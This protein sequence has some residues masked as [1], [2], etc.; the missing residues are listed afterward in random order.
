MCSGRFP[1]RDRSYSST[2]RLSPHVFLN[3]G[4]PREGYIDRSGRDL[5]VD[6]MVYVGSNVVRDQ[7]LF[8]N[9]YRSDFVATQH[10]DPMQRSL[11][12]HVHRMNSTL[13]QESGHASAGARGVIFANV[14]RHLLNFTKNPVH[15]HMYSF[16]SMHI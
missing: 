15:Q 4:C 16:S 6:N 8:K 3:K 11:T 12:I 13:F 2:T 9:S 14:T 5:L 7:A 1:A 10:F